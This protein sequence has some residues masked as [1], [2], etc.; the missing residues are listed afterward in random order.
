MRYICYLFIVIITFLLPPD[1]FA[2]PVDRHI[3][4]VIDG[5]EIEDE[6]FNLVFKQAEMPLNHLGFL[7]DYVDVSKRLPGDEEMQKYFAVISWFTDNQLKNASG[8]V[9]WATRQLNRGKKFVILDE[10]GFAFDEKGEPT[11]PE[12]L[13]DFLKAFRISFDASYT[14]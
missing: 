3:L 12:V 13:D 7:V 10:A 4:A 8:Y 9:R 5:A 11:P 1:A 14:S 6:F 2:R